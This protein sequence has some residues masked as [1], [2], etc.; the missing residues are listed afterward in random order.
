VF[1]IEQSSRKNGQP[2][3]NAIRKVLRRRG[4]MAARQMVYELHVPVG[5][6]RGR[7]ATKDSLWSGMNYNAVHQRAI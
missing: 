7:S 3:A 5:Y 1:R 2:M 4:P 6:L